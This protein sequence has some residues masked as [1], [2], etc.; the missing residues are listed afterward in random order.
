MLMSAKDAR[1]GLT[2]MRRAVESDDPPPRYVLTSSDVEAVPLVSV[3]R[4]V[5]VPAV[6]QRTEYQPEASV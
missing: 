1:F 4:M 2:V 6:R 3:K 5:N